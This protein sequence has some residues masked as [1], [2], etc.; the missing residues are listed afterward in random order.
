MT[1]QLSARTPPKKVTS[2]PVSGRSSDSRCVRC[3]PSRRLISAASRDEEFPQWRKENA[4]SDG[5]NSPSHRLQRPGRPGVSP[6]FPVHEF[7]IVQISS[8]QTVWRES[9]ASTSCR[10]KHYRG[11]VEG[12]FRD[13]HCC[14]WTR[15]PQFATRWQELERK[16][17][18]PT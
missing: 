5:N 7:A 11:C 12:C 4:T 17:F 8:P 16:N 2:R 10:V 3:M 6:E 14:E 1:T 9:V 15:T 18:L 13:Q